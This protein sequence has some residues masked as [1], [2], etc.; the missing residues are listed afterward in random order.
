M[1]DFFKSLS[2]NALAAIIIV[3]GVLFIV[4]SDPPVTKCSHQIKKFE[5][6]EIGNLIKDKNAKFQEETRFQ[7]L[8]GICKTANNLGGCFQLFSSIRQSLERGRTISLD[9][10]GEWGS[11]SVVKNFLNESTKIMLELPWG[12]AGPSSDALKLSWFQSPQVELFCKLQD[13]NA[14]VYGEEGWGQKRETLLSGLPNYQSL[15]RAK[16]WGLSLFS[17]SCTNYRFG[18][19]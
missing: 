14:L 16:A 6:A 7:K 1:A 5:E 17:V 12:P 11:S 8:V 13:V 10:Q 3:A 15:G 9:C 4:A 19:Y 18:N 2:K